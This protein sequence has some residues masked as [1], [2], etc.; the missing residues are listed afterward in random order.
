MRQKWRALVVV[1]LIVSAGLLAAWLD[2]GPLAMVALIMLAALAVPLVQ[3]AAVLVRVRV[4]LRHQ[5]RQERAWQVRSQGGNERE[6]RRQGNKEC[7][8]GW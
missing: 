3:L 7:H 5:R 6:S 4:E 1:A 8:C 2:L